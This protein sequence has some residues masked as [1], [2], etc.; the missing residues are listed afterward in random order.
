[1]PRL[2][3]REKL[4]QPRR[5]CVYKDPDS[6]VG[7]GASGIV[8]DAEVVSG[9]FRGHARQVQLALH[10]ARAPTPGRET[11]AHAQGHASASAVF[12]V[13]AATTSSISLGTKNPKLSEYYFFFCQKCRNCIMQEFNTKYNITTVTFSTRGTLVTHFQMSNEKMLELM[14]WS[15]RV[16]K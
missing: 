1:M 16:V 15:G 6:P 13:P 7:V 9:V 2:L 8:S 14:A 10:H 11:S 4:Q 3:R 5:N 12:V